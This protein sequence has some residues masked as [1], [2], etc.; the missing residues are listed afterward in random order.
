MRKH[1][2][3]T[4]LPPSTI[5]SGPPSIVAD[6]TENKIKQFQLVGYN[7]NLKKIDFGAAMQKVIS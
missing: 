6:A 2:R 4:T 5:R 1:V 7:L 3:F